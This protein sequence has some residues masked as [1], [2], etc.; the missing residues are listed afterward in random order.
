MAHE[1]KPPDGGQPKPQQS[2]PGQPDTEAFRLDWVLRVLE[3]VLFCC[4]STLIL[5]WI[6]DRMRDVG[7][8]PIAVTPCV[9]TQ[10]TPYVGPYG[11]STWAVF[12][13]ALSP[14]G[15]TAL[16]NVN[17]CT[18]LVET[19]ETRGED[20]EGVAR[21][22]DLIT[23]RGTVTVERVNEATLRIGPGARNDG[24]FDAL[25]DGLSMGTSKGCFPINYKPVFWPLWASWSLLAGLRLLRGRQRVWAER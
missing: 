14:S 25:R 21:V 23:S 15:P 1:A 22:L 11:G 7:F 10:C 9:G 24:F 5:V 6:S 13:D 20:G 12:S 8:E 17:I 3:A 18:Q 19:L 4:L 2:D 16:S